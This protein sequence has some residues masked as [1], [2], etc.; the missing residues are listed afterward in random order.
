[1]AVPHASG[2]GSEPGAAA[3][4]CLENE[5]LEDECLED[6]CWSRR[7]GDR[8][9][10]LAEAT[11]VALLGAGERL[12]PLRDLVE[13]LVARS[14]SEARVHLG[15]LVRLTRDRRLQVVR[16]G[17]DW[18]TGHRVA[19]GG[20][21]VEVTERVPG[22]ALGDGAEQRGDVGVALDVGLLSEVEVPAVGLALAGEG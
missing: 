21:E 5:C 16:G 9:E 22:L 8:L 3:P 14:A 17:A 10:P 11:G 18:L 19:G 1:M 6:E 12:E 2:P 7:S 13:T 4:T 20:E 15:V